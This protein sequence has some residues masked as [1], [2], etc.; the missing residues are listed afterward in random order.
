MAENPPANEGEI[1]DAGLIPGA[2]R[3]TGEGNGNPLQYS[4][5]ENSM[6]RGAW[7]ASPQGQKA[8]ARPEVTEHRRLRA[9]QGAQE[10]TSQ[11]VKSPPANLGDPRD[12]GSMSGSRRSPEGGNGNPL[13]Y[14]CLEDPRDGGAWWAAVYGVT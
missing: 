6:D 9:S 2:G 1:R 11:V 10:F 3:P 4:F 5:L 14:S 13:Q 8:S 7:Q 12:G